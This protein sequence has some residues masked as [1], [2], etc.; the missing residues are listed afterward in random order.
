MAEHFKIRRTGFPWMGPAPRRGNTIKPYEFPTLAE[1]HRM[2]R[3]C[4]N[5]P[6]IE[7][8]WEIGHFVNKDMVYL[9]S[10]GGNG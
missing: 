8:G 7:G 5:G 2:I 9:H 3:M 10:N 4:E 1:A 6:I